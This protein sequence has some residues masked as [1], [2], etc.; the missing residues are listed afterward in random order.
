MV[1]RVTGPGTPGETRS[2][3]TASGSHLK[4][5]AHV[6]HKDEWL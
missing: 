2:G 3:L 5:G 1:T 4:N 6:E